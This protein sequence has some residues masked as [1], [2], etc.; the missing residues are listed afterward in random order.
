MFLL[1]LIVCA[2]VFLPPFIPERVLKTPAGMCRFF[3]KFFYF[4]TGPT[5]FCEYLS[6]LFICLIQT[7]MDFHIGM[8]LHIRI[9]FY[10]DVELLRR[11]EFHTGMDFIRVWNAII[12]PLQAPSLRH[13]YRKYPAPRSGS[14]RCRPDPPGAGGQSPCPRTLFSCTSPRCSPDIQR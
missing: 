11:M 10:I 8:E 12:F 9:E 13:R 2:F 14:G 6:D 5:G 7:D 4:F 3:S 1:L